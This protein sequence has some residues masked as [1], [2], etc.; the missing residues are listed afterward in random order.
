M[1]KTKT[2][3]IT[4]AAVSMFA[5][6]ACT[7]TATEDKNV[8]TTQAQIDVQK[9]RTVNL[10]QDDSYPESY[11]VADDSDCAGR[12]YGRKCFIH[13]HYRFAF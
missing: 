13:F 3:I 8:Q 4:A 7:Q 12:Y 6:A 2:L 1:K 11:S 5:L 9:D 10:T